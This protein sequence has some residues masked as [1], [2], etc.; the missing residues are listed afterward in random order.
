M[1]LLR[2]FGK[3]IFLAFSFLWCLAIAISWKVFGDNLLWEQFIKVGIPMKFYT[4]IYLMV[5]CAAFALLKQKTAKWVFPNLLLLFASFV[6]GAGYSQYGMTDLTKMTS[7]N[8]EFNLPAFST[9]ICFFL[10]GLGLNFKLMGQ[11]ILS[12]GAAAIV[13]LA[14]ISSVIGNLFCVGFMRFET[15]PTSSMALST[16]LFLLLFGCLLINENKT[17]KS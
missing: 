7:Y 1:T 3:H 2:R 13:T 4:S 14:G 16:S 11:K 8:V 9:T 5:L 17:E 10:M 15:S 6:L 12:I